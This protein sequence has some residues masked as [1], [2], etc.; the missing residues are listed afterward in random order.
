MPK[1]PPRAPTKTR[2]RQS[3]MYGSPGR[4]SPMY[5]SP[6]SGS[7]GRGSVFNFGSPIRSPG[8]GSPGFNYGSPLKKMKNSPSDLTNQKDAK[9]GRKV[10]QLGSAVVK[11]YD[12]DRLSQES[13]KNELAVYEHLNTIYRGKKI[14]DLI[15]ERFQD[16]NSKSKIYQGV[17][18]IFPTKIKLE[19]NELH[20]T[21]HHI[22]DVFIN[23]SIIAPPYID[24][25]GVKWPNDP[26]L[27]EED[28]QLRE[29]IKR[30]LEENGI[31]YAD[32]DDIDEE[33]KSNL[34]RTEDENALLLDFE[35]SEVVNTSKG[36]R[37]KRTKK[38]RGGME[39]EDSPENVPTP[40]ILSREVIEHNGL[41][42]G[43]IFR[44][45]GEDEIFRVID[46]ERRGD[47]VGINAEI[48]PG[49]IPVGTPYNSFRRIH[50]NVAYD[51]YRSIERSVSKKPFIKRRGGKRKRTRKKRNIKKN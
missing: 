9:P 51:R 28:K 32:K 15:N 40:N 11:S 50:F 2:K 13:L 24:E 1:T 44:L 41:K 29:N 4:V 5:G 43:D 39:S 42:R 30:A 45:K 23:R 38:Q 48:Y 47:I 36:G 14:R 21:Y 33:I 22:K 31:I 6:G 20:L 7:P 3:P 25:N 37:K 17:N 26:E 10:K 16:V 35:T 49:N 46:I 8:S 27:Y 19:K 34:F 12:T 18:L